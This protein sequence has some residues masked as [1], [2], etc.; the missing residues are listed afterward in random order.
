MELRN[1]GGL[2]QVLRGIG[3]FVLSL[4][5]GGAAL[6]QSE[7]AATPTLATGSLTFG[8]LLG[9][10]FYHYWLARQEGRAVICFLAIPAASVILAFILDNI[11]KRMN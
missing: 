3:G 7:K 2:L 4:L 5:I 11:R 1:F 9:F 10:L 6:T 8:V